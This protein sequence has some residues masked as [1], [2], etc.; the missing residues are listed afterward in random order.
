MAE[1]LWDA[2]IFPQGFQHPSRDPLLFSVPP[3]VVSPGPAL[4][5]DCGRPADAADA[6]HLRRFRQ[7]E[8][9]QALCAPLRALGAQMGY[10]CL[11]IA[12]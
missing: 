8:I 5:G 4:D 3:Q 7:P 1:F 10:V 12:R 11:P 9:H 2:P 6:S